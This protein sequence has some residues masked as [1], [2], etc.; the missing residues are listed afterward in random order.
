LEKNG[1]VKV[2]SKK[3][4]T[5]PKRITG[6]L[7]KFITIIE[8]KEVTSTASIISTLPD[9]FLNTPREN[10][11]ADIEKVDLTLSAKI[12]KQD[13]KSYIVNWISQ[14]RVFFFNRKNK[15]FLIMNFKI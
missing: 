9:S 8:D 6:E 12:T 1:L 14:S 5:K 3:K 13:L 2:N 10:P 15:I 11:L 7:K 4:E